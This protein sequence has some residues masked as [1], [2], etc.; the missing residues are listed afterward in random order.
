[1]KHLVFIFFTL[2]LFSIPAR[3][4]E[5]PRILHVSATAE[6]TIPSTIAEVHVGV[7]SEPLPSA[8]EAQTA[9]AATSSRLVA[10]LRENG[11]EN[12]ETRSLRLTPQR[13]PN[14]ARNTLETRY[15]AQNIVSFQTEPAQVGQLL[16]R[17]VDMG[18]TRI[19]HVHSFA[20]PEERR[21]AKKQAI[22]EA[23]AMALEDA[24][25]VLRALNLSLK[26]V[27]NVNLE[28][29]APFRAQPMRR[30]ATEAGQNTAFE[31]G[32]DSVSATVYMSITY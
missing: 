32:S 17:T 30:M 5:D 18:A 26:E 27:V 25:A 13:Q 1:M 24:E 2:S 9:V 21:A 14:E 11:V 23:T 16:D 28:N 10:L 7:V 6:I 8:R 31:A 12:I 29:S 3:A 19:D 4:E 15:V 20:S 22:A